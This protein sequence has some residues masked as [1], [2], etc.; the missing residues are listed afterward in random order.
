M[1]GY[2]RR[3]KTRNVMARFA[4]RSALRPRNSFTRFCVFVMRLRSN[5]RQRERCAEDAVSR[6]HS[7]LS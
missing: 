2:K 7:P 6:A 1:K 3:G 4:L 5:A